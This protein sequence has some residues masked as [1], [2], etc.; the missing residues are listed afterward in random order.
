MALLLAFCMI[1][2]TAAGFA[3]EEQGVEATSQMGPR[4]SRF[5]CTEDLPGDVKYLSDGNIVLQSVAPVDGQAD[6]KIFKVDSEGQPIDGMEA[7]AKWEI[8][9]GVPNMLNSLFEDSEGSVYTKGVD[10]LLGIPS[11]FSGLQDVSYFPQSWIDIE[12]KEDRLLILE[13]ELPLVNPENI[14]SN[15]LCRVLIGFRRQGESPSAYNIGDLINP[16]WLSQFMNIGNQ[17]VIMGADFGVTAEDH[18]YL[19][20]ERQAEGIVWSIGHFSLRLIDDPNQPIDFQLVDRIKVKDDFNGSVPVSLEYDGL[21][22]QILTYDLS[23]N[24]SGIYRTDM[25]GNLTDSI[26]WNG[27]GLYFD[28]NGNEAI[29]STTYTDVP[30]PYAPFSYGYYKI[31]WGGESTDPSDPTEPS[32]PLE[33]LDPTDSTKTSGRPSALINE[34]S[35]GGKTVAVFR[36]GCY[37]MLK[38]KDPETGAIDYWVPLRSEEKEVRLRMPLCDVMAKVG[39]FAQNLE[40]LYGENRIQIPMTALAVQDLLSQMPCDTDATIEIQL[41]RGQDGSVTVTAELF[42]VEQVDSMTKVVH[43]KPIPLP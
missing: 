22:F 18:Y 20:G 42:V 4:M 33:P 13:R 21:G 24:E 28:T 39:E 11:D 1:V 38:E 36:E 3:I 25:N 23:K 9:S 19:I 40:I 37:G 27:F 6:M 15:H 31:E 34:R 16:G 7:E 35:V 2:G 8:N 14:F 5:F 17:V 41:V 12:S 10:K 30:T 26:T 32:D 29:V 43:R